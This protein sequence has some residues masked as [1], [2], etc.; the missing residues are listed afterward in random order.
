MSKSV[1]LDNQVAVGISTQLDWLSRILREGNEVKAFTISWDGEAGILSGTVAMD[2]KQWIR[3]IIAH[4]R[5][6]DAAARAADEP[7]PPAPPD[8][9]A[10][11]DTIPGKN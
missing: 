11:P 3:G 8:E 6:E 1:K 9:G 10:A 5:G 2:V 4:E 7:P